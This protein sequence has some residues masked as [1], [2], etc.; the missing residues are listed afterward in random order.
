LPKLANRASRFQWE[1]KGSKS[2]VE[3]AR[4]KAKEILSQHEPPDLDENVKKQLKVILRNATKQLTPQKN[5]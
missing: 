4:E 5:H 2:I 3:V 1:K